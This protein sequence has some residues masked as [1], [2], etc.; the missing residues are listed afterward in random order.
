MLRLVDVV[1]AWFALGPDYIHLNL[2][3]KQL[4]VEVDGPAEPS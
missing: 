4:R 1:Y 2:A 3:S